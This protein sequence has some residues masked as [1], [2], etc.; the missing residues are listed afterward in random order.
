MATI[1]A[2]IRPSATN[3]Q[4][5]IAKQRDLI[6]RYC[7]KGLGEPYWYMD[8]FASGTRFLRDR[9]AGEQLSRQLRRGDH[10]VIAQL[11]R[12]F[13]RLGDCVRMLDQ[14]QRLDVHLHICQL[15]G[16]VSIDLGSPLGKCLFPLLALF[17]DLE[18]SFH[19]ERT[20]EA[21][22]A[23]QARGEGIGRPRY[24]YKY[25]TRYRTLPNGER[26]R[27]LKQIPDEHE[28]EVMKMILRWRSEDPPWSWDHI[29]QEIAYRLK[30]KTSD[31]REWSESRIRRACQAEAM[32]QLQEV[33]D[34]PDR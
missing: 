29:R 25:E 27:F 6:T 26:Q 34:S 7:A 20:G 8:S 31:G 11:D 32:L 12:A 33:G 4:E 2:Y 17:A 19:A 24:G 21:S 16:G 14:F 9:E 5:S 10:V 13:R 28:R 15:R 3:P 22:R 23:R 18:R 1:H 30:L